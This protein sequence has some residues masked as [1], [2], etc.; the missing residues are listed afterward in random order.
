MTETQQKLLKILS[1]V[2]WKKTP[3]Q[4]YSEQE[5]EEILSTAEDQGVL[6]LVLQ[7]CMSI[8]QQLSPEKW[9]KWR[10]KLISTMVNNEL[11]MATQSKIIDGMHNNGIPCAVLKGSSV[12]VCYYNP[13]V[14]A[15]GDIDLLVPVELMEQASTVLVS[16]GFHAPKDSLLHPYHVDFYQNG[17]VVELHHAVSTF[18]DSL[19]GREA[20]RYLGSWQEQIQQKHIGNHTFQCLSDSQQALSL[21]IH[22]ER[23][24]ITGCIGLRQ[25]CDWAAFLT[26]ITPDSIEDQILPELKLCGLAEF[27]AILTQTAVCFL[28]LDS[29]YETYFLSTRK[30]YVTAMIKEILR[31]GSI[32]NRN[33]TEDSS[34]FFVEESGTKSSM[35]VFISKMNLLARKKCPC[36]EKLPFL[37]PIFWLYIP[38]RYWIRSLMGKR[39]RKSLL[40]TIAITKQRKQLYREMKLFK[41]IQEK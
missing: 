13:S 37:L 5:W 16:Q 23:H 32:H 19:A 28:G 2:L 40:R 4:E 12:S 8:R 39:R 34:S 25:L 38:L 1:D 14:R 41:G 33:N 35:R 30:R 21:L 7:G 10:S 17:V 6:F 26:S 20:K 11:L 24:M 29:V 22:M 27:A 15:L 18:P 3:A 36:T 9:L 31:A